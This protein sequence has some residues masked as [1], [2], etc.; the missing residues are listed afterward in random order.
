M[1]LGLFFGSFNPP[2]KSHIE[3]AYYAI[4]QNYV[5][6]VLLIPNYGNP[7]HNKKLEDS[8]HRFN[9]LKTIEKENKN[10]E[11]S[12]IE[13]KRGKVSYTYEILD[14]LRELYKED[15]LFLIVGSDIIKE[16]K[17]W[18]NYEYILKNYKIIINKRNNDNI[19]KI[20]D[21]EYSLYKD[22]L[23]VSNIVVQNISSTL[24]REAIYN[25]E[26]FSIYVSKSI[27]EYIVN[28]NLYGE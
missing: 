22:N 25:K 24:V 28:N 23:I 14:E 15:E 26:D 19:N 11:V 4:D 1:K 27:Y 6:K 21:D 13:I 2:T 5:D 10:I 7:L 20:I 12:D 18:K 8:F 3:L 16:F 17:K 9:M